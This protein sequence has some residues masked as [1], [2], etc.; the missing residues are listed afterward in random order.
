MLN[1]FLEPHEEVYNMYCINS[2]DRVHIRSDTRPPASNLVNS[3]DKINIEKYI[4]E[5]LS[6][7]V[8]SHWSRN[9]EARLSLV[10]R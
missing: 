5:I 9:V 10:Q 4:K 1:F 3:P 7:V 8:H 2:F 6:S